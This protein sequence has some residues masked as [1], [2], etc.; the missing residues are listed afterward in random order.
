MTSSRTFLALG[1]LLAFCAVLGARLTGV[2]G[3]SDAVAGDLASH[4]VPAHP[5]AERTPV[6]M[7]LPAV[8]AAPTETVAYADTLRQGET[9]S[10]LLSRARLAAQEVRVLMDE[11]LPHQ[12]PR[13]IRPGFVVSYLQSR[14][15]G[16]TRRIEAHLDRDRR[17]A[18]E[19]DGEGWTGALK[20]VPVRADTV[21]LEGEVRSS[22]YAAL[23][24]GSGEE[25]GLSVRER[26]RIADLLADAIFAWQ[27]DF[28]RD[29]R[30]GDRYR[31]LYE[32]LV[33]PDGTAREGRVLAVELTVNNRDYHAYH[34]SAGDGTRDY[35]DR[36][37]N[38]LRSAFLR[39]PLDYRRVSSVFTSNRL[40]PITG[41][42]RPHHGVD[43]AAP[44]GTPVRAAGDGTVQRAGRHG[45]YG[46]L[47]DIRHARGYMTRYAH[48]NGLA[49]GVTPGAR[50]RQGDVIG[51][52]GMTGLATGPHL[53]YEF[54]ANGRPVDPRTEVP[55]IT[56]EPVPDRH[57]SAFIGQVEGQVALLNASTA[58]V[59]AID[60][61]GNDEHRSVALRE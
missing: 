57:R 15:D 12:D 39:A 11:L 37:G 31:I 38:S 59:L 22:L 29:L 1:L 13:R 16:S 35:F 10:E 40:H 6:T 45:G 50:V 52:V 32:R 51:Y 49:P 2:S 25:A 48:L 19:R 20:E 30:R 47:V 41:R 28:A 36:H 26:E 14:Q 34:F 21:P 61:A 9:L 18:L 24:R 33:R 58:P 7:R 8:R 53:H 3:P 60:G 54:H 44:T 42:N 27:I 46:N 5:A 17:L 55:R 4:L 56:G 23:L 43:Y